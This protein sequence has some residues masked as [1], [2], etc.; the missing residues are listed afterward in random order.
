MSQDWH[1]EY[2]QKNKERIKKRMAEYRKANPDKVRETLKR[3]HEKNKPAR[4][5]AARQYQKDHPEKIRE[6]NKAW[7]AKNK[8]RLRVMWRLRQLEHYQ[9]ILAYNRAWHKAHPEVARRRVYRRR[10]N[11]AKIEGSHTKAEFEEKCVFFKGRCVYCGEKK[12]LYPDHVVPVSKGG[13]DYISNI[14]P[15]C[16]SCNSSKQ[17]KSEEE[18][19]AYRS[20]S[21]RPGRSQRPR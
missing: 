3:Y 9:E 17:A 1:A 6:L 13:T 14:V 18:F 5:A 8:D 11:L 15:A 10:L 2:Y 7:R 20:R 21:P 16:W 4:N 19:R 12:P